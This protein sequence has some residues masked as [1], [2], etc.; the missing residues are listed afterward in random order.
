MGVSVADG[1]RLPFLGRVELVRN[2]KASAR[3]KDRAD[4]EALGETPD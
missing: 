3:A 2:K 1:L 4:L